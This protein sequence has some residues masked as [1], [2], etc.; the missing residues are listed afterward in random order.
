M[1]MKAGVHPAEGERRRGRSHI[2][3][4]GQARHSGQVWRSSRRPGGTHPPLL[5]GGL[6]GLAG[7]GDVRPTELRGAGG[8]GLGCNLRGRI[9]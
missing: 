4:A 7:L 8:H 6:P 1:R 9:R 2:W 3:P 5:G